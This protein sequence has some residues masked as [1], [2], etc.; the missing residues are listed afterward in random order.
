M[1]LLISF[2][3]KFI[4]ECPEFSIV[5]NFPFNKIFSNMCIFS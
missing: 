3:L 5:I 2:A 1:Y 4:A